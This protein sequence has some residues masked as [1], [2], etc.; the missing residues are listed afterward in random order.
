MSVKFGIH[1]NERLQTGTENIKRVR[2]SVC[3]TIWF[4]KS[5]MYNILSTH[6]QKQ[7]RNTFSLTVNV[8]AGN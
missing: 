1:P 7:L 3:D 4:L 6:K 5:I 2:D 8:L